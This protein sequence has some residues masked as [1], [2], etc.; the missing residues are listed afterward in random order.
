MNAIYGPPKGLDDYLLKSQ[1]MAYDG[2]RAM[3]EAY[4]RNKYKST[5][6]I[7][8][9]LNNAWPSVIWHLYDYYL[10]PAGGYFG[11]KKAC[12][13]LH[14]QYSYDDRSVVVVNSVTENYSDLTGEASLYNFNLRR[15]FYRKINMASAADSV[16][17]LFNIPSENIDTGCPFCSVDANGQNWSHP[18]CEL[19]LAAE[20]GYPRYDWSTETE[21]KHPYYTEVV[22]YEDLSMLNQLQKVHLE[23]SASAT[24]Q[25]EGQD[26]RVH[27]HNPSKNLA[28]QIHLAFVDEKSGEE[29]VPV[30]WED[31]YLSLMPGKSRDVVAHYNSVASS[32]HLRLQM[33]GWNII[34]QSSLVELT[35]PE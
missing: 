15:L 1:A 16:Q 3:F 8:W 2:E 34:P 20:E 26:V 27:I 33:N 13:P 21:K 29:I 30:F 19:L 35:T 24:R 10:Q 22:S 11:T 4:G 9:M 12:E 31:N 18:E 5:G 25:A 7:E 17:R 6:V 23:V 14:I 28:F 32:S